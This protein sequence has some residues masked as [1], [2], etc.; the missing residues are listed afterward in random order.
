MPADTSKPEVI[1]AVFSVCAAPE[2]AAAV[3]TAVGSVPDSEFIG[4]FQEYISSDKRPQFPPSLT[5]AVGCVAIIDC[6]RDSVLAFETMERLKQT[7]LHKISLVAIS[8][9]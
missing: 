4:E 5:E 2:V 7:F 1:Q 9:R 8:S 6:D 3:V